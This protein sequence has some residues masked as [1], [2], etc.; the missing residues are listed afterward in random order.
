MSS[1]DVDVDQVIDGNNE[2]A[3]TP[4]DDNFDDREAFDPGNRKRV[5]G[6]KGFVLLMSLVVLGALVILG[7]RLLKTDEEVQPDN[8]PNTQPATSSR[9][10][11]DSAPPAPPQPQQ[12]EAPP[13]PE[14]TPQ[15]AVPAPEPD[16]SFRMPPPD[17]DDEEAMTPEQRAM[18]RRLANFENFDSP[19]DSSG[20]GAGGGQQ[21]SGQPSD[22]SQSFFGKLNSGEVARAKA[23]RLE[24]PS[25]TVPQGTMILCGT[26]TELD[27]TVPGQVG[28]MVSREVYSADRRVRLIDKGAQISGLIGS[29]IQHG[30]ARVF[31]AWNRLRNPDNTVINIDSS[32]TNALGSAGIPG[33]VDT[34]FWDRFGG[35]L[36]VSAFGDLGDAAVQSLADNAGDS[37]TNIN[38][39]NTSSTTDQLAQEALQATIDIPPTLY[40]EQGKPVAIYVAK[41]LDFSDVYGLEMQ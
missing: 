17:S 30:Q 40:A 19:I 41:D 25:M 29:G 15:V 12:Q 10:Q 9:Y 39:N 38:L 24:H 7:I 23:S 6:A 16:N 21:G 20:S 4:P 34:H 18:Q 5:R 8:N 14:P 35:A 11:F 27:T 33:Q 3:G 1:R 37:N 31:V 22:D 36:L 28:C 2:N 32:G 13:S 26:T